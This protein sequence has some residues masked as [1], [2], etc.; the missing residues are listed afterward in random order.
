MNSKSVPDLAQIHQNV[1][2]VDFELGLPLF[3]SICIELD[4]AY[5]LGQQ[6]SWLHSS[7]H[8]AMFMWYCTLEYQP[9]RAHW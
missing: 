8:M 9:A 2:S 1:R 5:A 7:C 4:G 6:R 3:A